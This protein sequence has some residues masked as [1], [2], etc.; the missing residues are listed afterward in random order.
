MK[1]L[2]LSF[3]VIS[4][5]SIENALADWSSAKYFQC[6]VTKR[7]TARAKL[8]PPGGVNNWTYDGGCGYAETTNSSLAVNGTYNCGYS[9]AYRNAGGG[10]GNGWAS[11][12]WSWGE[13]VDNLQSSYSFAPMKSIGSPKPENDENLTFSE[14]SDKGIDFDASA[15]LISI[16]NLIGK[17]K[18]SS[19][20]FR[21]SFSTIQI[22]IYTFIIID[23]EPVRSK[24][25]WKAKASILNGKL[26]VEGGFS[27]RDFNNTSDGSFAQFEINNVSKNYTLPSEINIEDVCVEVSGDGGNLGN[28][29]SQKYAPNFSSEEGRN[30]L[31]DQTSEVFFDF[32]VIVN[33]GYVNALITKNSDEIELSEISIISLSGQT[34]SSK[35][36]I[37]ENNDLRLDINDLPS[38]V[39]LL[40]IKSADTY[41]SKKFFK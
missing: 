30:F 32:N 8:K 15:R 25:L 34:I 1:K 38:G 39:Y 24:S 29:I 28:G 2:I 6:A 10:T 16:N 26:F 27:P 18:I 37:F 9:Y 13:N 41:Y 11:C 23:G 36:N 19:T 3:I 4:F 33:N 7:Y 5:F 17:L 31:D 21:N 14:L 35:G 22:E 12:G 20:D 40:M